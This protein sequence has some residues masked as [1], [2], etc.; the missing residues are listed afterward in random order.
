MPIYTARVIRTITDEHA[1]TLTVE[2]DSLGEAITLFQ[3]E[4]V[5]VFQDQKDYHSADE[6]THH[7]RNCKI[8]GVHVGDDWDTSR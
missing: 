2:A 7:Y 6:Y 5:G 1:A 3:E 8:D 4:D